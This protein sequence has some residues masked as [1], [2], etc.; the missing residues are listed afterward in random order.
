MAIPAHLVAGAT[1]ALPAARMGVA[2]VAANLM[3][4]NA[5]GSGPLIVT[6]SAGQ[7]VAAS[8]RTVCAL[9]AGAIADPARR[10]RVAGG[11]GVTADAASY[12]T[13]VAG[14]RSMARGAAS[15]RCARF[16]SV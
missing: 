6:A 13:R 12:V 9:E 5:V 7:N 8:F 14:L 3:T 4:A 15:G 11:R 10:V 2:A 16:E 1:H